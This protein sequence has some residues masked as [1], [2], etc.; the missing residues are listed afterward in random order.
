MGSS[1]V[2]APP[3]GSASTC[4]AMPNGRAA[5]IATS[6]ARHSTQGPS[7]S[8]ACTLNSMQNMVVVALQQLLPRQVTE[9]LCTIL[10]TAWRSE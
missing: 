4:A 10:G 5:L 7:H 2:G 6:S 1:T 9:V 8:P 3:P